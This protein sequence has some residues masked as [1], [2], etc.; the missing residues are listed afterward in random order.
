MYSFQKTFLTKS[1]KPKPSYSKPHTSKPPKEDR[2]QS[3]SSPKEEQ[4]FSN[5]GQTGRTLRFTDNLLHENLNLDD[6][7]NLSLDSPARG[8]SMEKSASFVEADSFIEEPT[9]TQFLPPQLEQDEHISIAHPRVQPSSHNEFNIPSELSASLDPRPSAAASIS[10][11]NNDDG[12]APETPSTR[13]RRIKVNREVEKIVVIGQLHYTILCLS[14][15]FIGKDMEH[16]VRHPASSERSFINFSQRFNVSLR[17][18]WL[19][20]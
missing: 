1:Q 9:V 14:Q 20:C 10:S 19:N 5:T 16:N 3:P 4:L 7:G 13:H 8:P 18:P 2:V 12:G 17:K 15:L 6:V 11:S